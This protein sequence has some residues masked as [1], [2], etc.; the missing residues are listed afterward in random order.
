MEWKEITKDYTISEKGDIV[1]LK[2]QI[3]LKQDINSKGYKWIKLPCFKKKQLIHRLVASLFIPN[4]E[5]KPQVNHIDG[6]KLNNH[7]SNLEWCTNYENHLHSYKLG[8]QS[9]NIKLSKEQVLHIINS[10]V[11]AKELA[12]QYN[13][14]TEA[15]YALRKG[16]NLKRLTT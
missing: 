4:P 11:K 16:R 1:S 9:P 13:I 5:N 7:Y 2:R 15:I 3:L 14:S 8:R 6:N 12:L 10:S